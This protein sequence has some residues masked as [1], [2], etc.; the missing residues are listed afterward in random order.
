MKI[1]VVDDSPTHRAINRQELQLGDY[2]ILEAQDGMEALEVLENTEVDLI[3]LDIEMP[4]MNGYETFQELR[5]RKARFQ[6]AGRS[7]PPVIFVTAQ[8]T[9]AEREKGFAIGAMDYVVKPYISGELLTAVDRILK[10]QNTYKGLTALVVDDSASIRHMVADIL[11][12]EGLKV[13]EAE[14]GSKALEA[15]RENLRQ[16]DLVVTDVVMPEMSGKELCLNIRTELNR[17]DI[18]IFFMSTLSEKSLILDMFKA[19]GTDYFV[20]P[21]TKEEFLARLKVHL[22]VRL[23]NKQL[24]QNVLEL[25]KLH[26][27]KDDFLAICS[28]DLRNPLGIILNY[29]NLMMQ[30]SG[31]DE[32][33]IEGLD[34]IRS[35]AEFILHMVNE[36][37]DLMKMQA[38]SDDLVLEPLD[39]NEL[40]ISCLKPLQTIA[41]TKDIDLWFLNKFDGDARVNANPNAMKRILNNLISN[42]IKFTDRGGEMRLEIEPHGNDSVCLSIT[43][44][45]SGIPEDLLPKLFD[46]YSKTAKPGTEGEKGTGL[47][48]SIVKELA[49][50]QRGNI[51]VTSEPEKGSCFKIILPLL[52]AGAIGKSTQGG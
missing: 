31:L 35:S 16:L 5:N 33:H 13:I 29:T 23:M 21:F 3:S 25:K 18:P 48:L 27:L 51:V 44:T 8:D 17:K 34:S 2:E 9:L 11:R 49:V 42:G 38:E 4:V 43:D 36:L 14:D 19:G 22:N 40:A 28:H 45:G 15:A 1:L 32:D 12:K 10:P 26:K 30:D 50:K 7:I 24:N 6:A 37:L 41:R 46:K 47:G 52:A 20:K 39:L